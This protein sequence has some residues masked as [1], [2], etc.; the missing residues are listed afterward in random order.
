MT[1][2]SAF[3][4]REVKDDMMCSFQVGGPGDIFDYTIF[5]QGW[6][7]AIFTILKANFWWKCFSGGFFT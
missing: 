5:G 1:R 2:T 4:V 3:G 6:I 7:Y